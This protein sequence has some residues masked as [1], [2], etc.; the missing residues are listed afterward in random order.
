MLFIQIR[1]S[2]PSKT[3][4]VQLY[5]LWHEKIRKF[6]FSSYACANVFKDRWNI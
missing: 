6:E 1:V 5:I 2:E 4:N 3:V